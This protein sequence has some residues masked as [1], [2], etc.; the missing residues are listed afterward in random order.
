MERELRDAMSMLPRLDYSDAVAARSEMNRFLRL[1]TMLGS[2]T[3]TDSE[4]AVIDRK[5][6][7]DSTVADEVRK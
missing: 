4:V 2:R 7:V 1:S 3:L 6:D 5:P